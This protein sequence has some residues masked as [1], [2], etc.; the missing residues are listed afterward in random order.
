MET[1]ICFENDDPVGLMMCTFIFNAIVLFPNSYQNYTMKT[2]WNTLFRT[3]EHFKIIA[4]AEKKEK[5]KKRKQKEKKT[6][7]KNKNIDTLLSNKKSHII[8]HL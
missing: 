5:K 4:Q 8:S 2:I 6:K 1:L 3:F 7:T